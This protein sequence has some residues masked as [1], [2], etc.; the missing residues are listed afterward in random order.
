VSHIEPKY[1]AEALED[2]NWTLALQDELN[3]FERILQF[4]E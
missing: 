4:D 2:P 1:Y 3:Q